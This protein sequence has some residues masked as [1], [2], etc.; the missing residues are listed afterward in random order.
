M[1][2][3]SGIHVVMVKESAAHCNA[4]FFPPIVVTSGYFGYAYY[5]Q[6]YLGVIGLHVIALGFVWLA[7]CGCHECSCWSGSFVVCWSAIVVL[8]IGGIKTALQ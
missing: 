5:H 2:P 1:W 7:D 6:F 8:L 4:V 3:S